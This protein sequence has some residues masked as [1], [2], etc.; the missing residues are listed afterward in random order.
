MKRLFT[1]LVLILPFKLRAQSQSDTLKAR[2]LDEVV[3]T[4]SRVIESILVS[5]VSVQK[6]SA[7]ATALAPALSFFDALEN[8]QGVH[9]IT[10]SMGF[11]VLNARGF[12][13]TTNVRFAQLTDGMDVQSPHIGGAIGNAL[14]P[15]D[16]D[17]ASIEILPGTAS[18]LY[19]MNTVNGLANFFTKNPFNSEGLSIQQK[20]AVNHLN[21]SHSKAR[22]FTETTLRFAKVITP[23]LAFKING[24]FTKG[25]DWIASDETE[26]NGN[27]NNSTQLF[28]ADNPASDPV[29]KYGN[30]SSN[31]KTVTLDGKRYVVSRTGY[32]E[33]EVVD[34]HLHN[35]K[36][37]LGLYYKVAPGAMLTYTYH[38]GLL[39]NVYQRANRFRLENYLVQQHGIQYQSASVQARLYVNSENTGRSYNL[40][41]MA[42]NMDR[43]YKSDN[44]WYADFSKGFNSA[45]TGGV[46]VSDAMRQ[47]RV[48][49]DAGRYTPGTDAFNAQL[50][51]LQDVNNWDLGAALRVKADFVHA[52]AQVS[53]TE[54]YLKAWK[55]QYGLDILLGADHRTYIIVPDG[56]YFVNPEPGKDGKNI[57]YGKTGGFVS[58]NKELFQKQIRLGVILRMDKN[59]YFKTTFNPRLSAVYSPAHDHNIR[60]S[61]QTGYRFPSIFEAYSNVNSGGVKRVGGLPVMSQGIFENAWLANSI[62]SF[63][64][65]VLNEIN[66]NGLTQDAAIEKN[67]GLL[68]KNP[69]TYVKP[70][71]TRTWE[72]GYKG[73]FFDRALFVNA[74][75]YFNR[76]SNFIA[77]T[78][79]NVPVSTGAAAIPH[80]LYDKARQ[81]QYRMY[82]N[83][84]SIINNYGF[85][86]GMN[87]QLEKKWVFGLNTTFAKL[88]NAENQDGLEDGFNT[89]RWIWNGSV[90]R[91]NLLD[92]L[93]ATVSYKW[94]SGY[95]S[96]TFLVTGNV[97][98]YSSLDA[99]VTYRVP[100][101]KSQVKVGASN[102]LNKYYVSFLGGPSVGGMWYVT[103]AFNVE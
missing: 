32:Q 22:P 14:G 58:L 59:D 42:E 61:F 46:A 49:A 56:N 30:E 73:L 5:P 78:N 63:Q 45:V 100:R 90:S 88:K 65:A 91:T 99:Q 4:A 80:D 92:R 17:I 95:Y 50:R 48:I 16:L 96:Q 18:A 70:E 87:Y 38:L 13:N 40:R 69:Y 82:T 26:L 36:G 25:Y 3:V 37:D 20:T 103:V 15:T 84:R 7:K 98:S 28:G 66:Q 39:D 19:G 57:T 12:S 68:K 77:Q 53:L 8:V 2:S 35:I 67:K 71:H 27:A 10:P 55:D 29:N 6:V 85:S 83:S 62:A 74:D 24:A 21:D 76:Y 64:Q 9:M 72:A 94:Q 93:D 11:K 54:K 97:P 44:E 47:A 75:L 102:L 51:K 31:R 86:V 43:S 34:Y 89:P 33:S 79:M 60:V 1:A 52:E 23:K 81:A 41:S 101:L